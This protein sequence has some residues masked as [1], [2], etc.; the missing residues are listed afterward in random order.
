VVDKHP[1]AGVFEQRSNFHQLVALD[2]NVNEEVQ[3]PE[4]GQ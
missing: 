2:L 3:I 1:Y 4:L